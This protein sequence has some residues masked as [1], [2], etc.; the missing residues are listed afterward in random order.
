M[1]RYAFI[2]NLVTGKAYLLQDNRMI[3]PEPGL[4][5]TWNSMFKFVYVPALKVWLYYVEPTLTDVIDKGLE[6]F[7]SAVDS[8]L[9]KDGAEKKNNTP[10]VEDN[11]KEEKK[12]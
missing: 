3:S 2:Q 6:L 12:K 11:V 9:G 1:Y 10:A 7:D 4:R 5:T 8:I